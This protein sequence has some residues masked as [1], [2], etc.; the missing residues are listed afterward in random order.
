MLIFSCVVALFA[1]LAIQSHLIYN[2]YNLKE[3]EILSDVSNLLTENGRSV[4]AVDDTHEQD[5]KKRKYLN[6]FMASKGDKKKL[7]AD[8]Q[9]D[10]AKN[11]KVLADFMKEKFGNS[12]YEISVVKTIT[13]IS[14]V[15]DGI[16][17]TLFNGE[18]IIYQN[19]KKTE[20]LVRLSEG[21]MG[22]YCD[23]LTKGEDEN[24]KCRY[25]VGLKIMYSV[26]NIDSLIFS[27]MLSLFVISTS[28]VLFVVLVFYLS[29]KNLLKQKRIAEIQRDFINNITH[30]F[31]TPLATLT[32]ATETLQRKDLD[33][34][35]LKNTTSIIERQNN[36]LQKIFNKASF[37]S[38]L[39]EENSNFEKVLNQ[40][41]IENC[42]S[43]FK[44]LNP[45][46]ELLSQIEINQE[47]QMS[48]FHFNTVLTNLLENA[49]KYKGTKID[50]VAKIEDGK[51]VFS[52]SDN[53]I[54]IPK[55]EHKAIFDKFYRIQNG[56]IHTTKGLGLGLFYTKQIIDKYSGKI[57]IIC[58]ENQGVKFVI[59]IPLQIQ[60]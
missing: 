30:E 14:V 13:H 48:R 22:I 52:V 36:R 11:S 40:A 12:K 26:D 34:K 1:L 46:I 29:L 19:K 39:S 35:T 27:E 56:D 6:S 45:K 51:F 15:Q 41:S 3:K 16:T 54:G 32:I 33:Q 53:G 18:I 44:L 60:A 43:D 38:M 9:T 17:D 49:V 7:V 10:Y 8:F 31:K 50:V 37:D 57:D 23:D 42:I 24:S 5:V 21:M 4:K 28:I 59:S 47:I 25:Q 2:T 58:H 55:K 20:K